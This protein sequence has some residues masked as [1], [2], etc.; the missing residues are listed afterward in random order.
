M[1][2][3]ASIEL[4][5]ISLTHQDTYIQDSTVW[6]TRDIRIIASFRVISPSG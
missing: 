2:F 3:R 4:R 5:S 6:E 1:N